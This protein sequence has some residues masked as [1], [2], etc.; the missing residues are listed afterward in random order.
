[1]LHTRVSRHVQLAWTTGGMS[2]LKSTQDCG[3]TAMTVFCMPS[4][5]S[6]PPESVEEG[7]RIAQACGTR[8]R[9]GAASLRGT[10]GRDLTN[11][12]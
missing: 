2:S 4:R 3:S 1:M 10:G 9:A 8:R 5:T 7:S 12:A 6:G 11:E